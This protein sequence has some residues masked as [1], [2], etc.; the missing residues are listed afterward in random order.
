MDSPIPKVT[1]G[2]PVYNGAATLG[3]ALDALLKQ[4]FADFEIVISDNASTDDTSD[5]CAKYIAEDARIRCYRQATNIGAELNFKFVLEQARAPYFMWSACD[6]LRSPDFLQENVQFLEAHPSYVAATSP[7]VLE[8]GEAAGSQLIAFSLDGS[9]EERIDAFF[10]NCWVS[11]GI[12]YA[13]IRTDAL[14]A[15]DILGQPF[16]GF[17]WA[18]DLYLASR[19]KIHRTQKGLMTSGMAGLSNRGYPWRQ[20]RTQPIGWLFPFHRVSLYVLK[21]S[22]RSS[23]KFRLTL[24]MRLLRLNLMTARVQFFSELRSLFPAKGNPSLRPMKGQR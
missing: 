18:V 4:T 9:L 13:L 15:C 8:G 21:L 24:V 20:Y 3:S 16:F 7:N 19:G 6:D 22:S 12:F 11:H 5:I 2:V 17:D 14:K 23:L 10:D 1:V